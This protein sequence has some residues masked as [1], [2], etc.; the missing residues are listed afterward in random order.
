MLA[1][2][3]IGTLVMARNAGIANVNV[4]R[5]GAEIGGAFGGEKERGRTRAGLRGRESVD[6]PGRQRGRVLINRGAAS[7]TFEC[8][9]YL[10]ERREGGHRWRSEKGQFRKSFL[11]TDESCWRTE[12]SLV[13][14]I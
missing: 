4:E 7:D 1:N 11:L 2:F 3:G 12:D 8:P 6:A 5:S 9:L 13:Q 14:P 10:R